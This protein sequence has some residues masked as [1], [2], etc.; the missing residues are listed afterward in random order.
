MDFD[1]LHTSSNRRLKSFSKPSDLLPYA[2]AISAGAQLE[3]EL[4]DG[5]FSGLAAASRLPRGQDLQRIRQQIWTS[6]AVPDTITSWIGTPPES[7]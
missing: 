2:P 7:W 1:Q 3:Q 5:A 4:R 6:A